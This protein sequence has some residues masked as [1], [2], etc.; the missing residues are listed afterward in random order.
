MV[1]VRFFDRYKDFYANNL[2]TYH[3]EADIADFKN[4]Y[5]IK[6]RGLCVKNR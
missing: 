5:S 4:V 2:Y 3:R 6:D 1:F